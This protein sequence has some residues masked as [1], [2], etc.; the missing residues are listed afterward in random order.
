MR[1]QLECTHTR[2]S[3]H[4]MLSFVYQ[5]KNERPLAN[6]Q[7]SSYFSTHGLQKK[8]LRKCKRTEKNIRVEFKLNGLLGKKI[9]RKYNHIRS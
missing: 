2:I 4:S 8:I 5:E 9:E 3:Y 7:K 6:S 1:R